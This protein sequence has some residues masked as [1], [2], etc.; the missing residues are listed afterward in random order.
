MAPFTPRASR[1]RLIIGEI[2]GNANK[3]AAI[4]EIAANGFRVTGLFHCD[5]NIFRPHEFPLAADDKD[6][7]PVNHAA[8]VKTSDQPSFISA[9]FSPFASAEALR[10]SNISAVPSLKLQPNTHLGKVKK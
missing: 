10:A 9:N 7:A 6:A 8:L 3:P 4:G 2:F 1:H 5:K